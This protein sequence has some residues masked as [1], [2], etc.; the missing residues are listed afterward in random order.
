MADEE[1]KT[2]H[3][4]ATSPLA[5][6]EASLVKVVRNGL[7]T[8]A[9][10]QRPVGSPP[11]AGMRAGLC[12]IEIAGRLAGADPDSY[13]WWIT[14][15]ALDGIAAELN[16]NCYCVIDNFQ[17]PK[18][19]KALRKEVSKVRSNGHLQLSRLAG[20]RSGTNVTYTHTA[21]RG[22]HVGWFDGA[23]PKLWKK[24][25]LT[26]YLSKVD[27]LVAQLA[28]KVPQLANIAHRSKAMVAC[29]PGGGA[30]YVRH[31]DNSCDS[32]NGERCNGR[33]LTAIMYLNERWTQLHG[34]E[35]RLFAPYAPKDVPPLCDVAPLA[36]RLVLFY[37]DYR[38]PHE[39][40][41]AHAE[42][43]AITA[44]YF[45]RAEHAKAAARGIGAESTDTKESEAIDNEIKKFEERFGGDGL[46]IH[47]D[48]KS[49]SS[50][51]PP[52]LAT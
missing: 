36:D 46:V 22:D 50:S 29:Y 40:L 51:G 43:L 19:A 45:D 13:W 3:E 52:A 17:G 10:T 2:E 32:G 25:T 39:V 31:C 47:G 44:W 5:S 15:E 27:T 41:P 28:E 11:P 20:G 9:F 21:V 35:L 8:W 26:R 12:K 42:R 34:G 23:E 38:V 4:K 14:D 49:S 30:R 6:D 33:R 18:A 7:S 16:R 48:K 24:D 1:S 37:A